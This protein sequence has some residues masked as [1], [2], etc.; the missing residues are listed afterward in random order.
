MA[1]VNRQEE[2]GVLDALAE[3]ARTGRSGILVITGEPGVGKTAL[4]QYAVESASDLRVLRTAGI[5]SEME[6]PFAALHQLCIP[7]LSQ[8]GRLPRAQRD[9]LSITFGLSEGPVPDRLFVGLATLGL[10]SAVSE[11]VPLVCIVDDAQWLDNASAQALVLVARRLFAES[12]AMIFAA[13]EPRDE[14]ALMPQLVIGGLRD[15]D[16][17]ELLRS[18]IVGGL[19]ERVIDQIVGETGGNPLGLLELPRGL[20]PARLAGGFGLPRA[21]SIQGKIEESFTLRLEAL[22]PDTRRLLLLAAAEPTGDAALVRRAAERLGLA[23]SAATPA[24]SAGLLVG[25]ARLRFRHPLVRSAVYRVASPKER[26]EAHRE[27]AHATDPEVDPDR[28]AWHIAEATPETDE[29]VAKELERAAGRAQA[30]GGL[31]AAAAFLERAA[32][33]TSE[34]SRRAERTL[35]AA[36]AKYEAGAFEDAQDLMASPEASAGDERQLA[37]AAQLQAEIEFVSR[38]GSDAP[39][40]LLKAARD[41]QRFEADRARATYLE[42]LTA[43]MLAG[44]LADEAGVVEVSE[45]VLAGPPAPDPPRP[46]DL[47]MRGLAV[48]FTQG[49]GAG[50]PILKETLSAFRREATLPPQEMRWLWLACWVA[51]DLWDD[52]T[53]DV[54]SAR[55][56]ELARAAGALTVVPLALSARISFLQQAAGDLAAASSMLGELVAVTE[57]VG[58]A[59]PPYG[60]ALDA[61]LRG[62]EPEASPLIDG[63]IREAA[64]RGEGFALA[65]AELA[66]GLMFN[67]L[68][69]YEEA[70]AAV[71]QA[72]ERPSDIGSPTWALSELI[73]AATRVGNLHSAERALARLTAMARASGSELALGIEARSRAQL[74]HGDAA[75]NLYREATAR[76]GRTR[77]RL[78]HARATLLYGEWLRREG[79]RVD[80]REQLRTAREK[81]V[82]IGSEGFA[83]RA[84]HELLATGER[85][86]KRGVDTRD[87]LTAQE[88]LIARLAGEGLSNPEIGMRLFISPRTAE[89]HLHKVFAKLGVSSRNQLRGALR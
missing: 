39:R 67:G 11:A 7:V 85:V 38:R 87:D 59:A 40:R 56:L 27:L 9:A 49:Y 44:S 17:R 55:Q 81:F 84:E 25:A 70:M 46:P 3:G 83:E 57:A 6:M 45:A 50:A 88:G 15:A 63:I 80:A 33:L 72:G 76:L 69:R 29:K 77:A 18:V 4:M 61:A 30:R 8:L 26:R 23:K 12:V 14:L 36:Q 42:A 65:T 16:A 10:L 58:I 82:K 71:S 48:R 60:A 62:R 51:A 68:G 19:D 89:Y 31:A 20:S 66:N 79:R 13:R 32:T 47:L 24:E 43:A 54:L 73:E 74:S 21:L 41:V 52:E 34:R 64:A 28:R 5:E 2:C 35:A 1:L 78:E 22:P 86:R 37:R 75:E 53:W